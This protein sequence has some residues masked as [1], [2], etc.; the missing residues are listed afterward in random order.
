MHF[1]SQLI[2]ITLFIRMLE[3]GANVNIADVHNTTP[4]MDIIGLG[5][6]ARALSSLTMLMKSSQ[7][8]MLDLD[9]CSLQS[10][11]WRSVFQGFTN[12][13]LKLISVG[14]KQF[15]SARVERSLKPS[16]NVYMPR[17]ESIKTHVPALL[18]P[19]LSDSPCTANLHVRLPKRRTGQE[20]PRILQCSW[21]FSG[22]LWDQT[23]HN[24]V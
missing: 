1:S 12:L 15:S 18:S 8:L 21:F 20:L 14:V 2:F 4:I 6:E 22:A 24:K 5:D 17:S 9:N 11:L 16:P 19:L 23:R 13:S 7:N 3:H 10:A